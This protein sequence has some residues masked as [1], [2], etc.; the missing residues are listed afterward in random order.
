MEMLVVAYGQSYGLPIVITRGNNVFGPHQYPEKA[1]P[2]FILRLRSKKKITLHG[3]GLTLRSYMH[4]SDAATA[5]DTV[6]HRGE[7]GEVYN[8]GVNKERTIRSVAEVREIHSKLES[9]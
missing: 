1:I 5:F 7:T 4:V 8:I 2:K 9:I 3:N 6:L